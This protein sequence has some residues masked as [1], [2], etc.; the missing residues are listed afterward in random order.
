MQI[1][2]RTFLVTGGGSGLGAATA[3]M[4]V[5]AGANVVLADVNPQPGEAL[6]AELGAAARFARTDV[7]DEAAVTEAIELATRKYGPLSGVVQCA[8][9]LGAGAWSARPERTSSHCSSA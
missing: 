4:L 2:K 5:A 7:T 3:R 9:I 6:A 1:S 8:G